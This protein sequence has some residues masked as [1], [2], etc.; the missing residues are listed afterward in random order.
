MIRIIIAAIWLLAPPIPGLGLS[1]RSENFRAAL[2]FRLGLPL[3][4]KGLQCPAIS[5]SGEI[6]GDELDVFGDHALCCHFG[7][8]RLFRHNQVRDIL[9]HS[10][11]AAQGCP[12]W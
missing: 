3:F 12:Q 4:E 1:L 9:G 7:T 6:C 10:A 8:S 2:K 11:K 5:K